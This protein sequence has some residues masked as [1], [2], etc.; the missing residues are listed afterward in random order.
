MAKSDAGVLLSFYGDDFS[1]SAATAETLT[2]TGVPT[3][4]FTQPPTA[5][6]L[7]GHF[8]Q[9]RAI[10]VAGTARTLAVD[11]LESH[12]V[13]LFSAMEGCRAPLFLYKV[14]S[15][16]DSSAWIGSIGRAME[17]GMEVLSAGLVPV[18]AGAP[19]LGRFTVFG[20][21]F[22]ALGQEAVYR[23]DRHPS[24]ANHPVT[25][26]KESDLRLHLAEQTELRSG[27]I[28]VLA[29]AKGKNEIQ[30]LLDEF[31]AESIPVIFLDCLFEEHLDTACQAI[32]ERA[33]SEG[34]VFLVGSHEVGYG[35]GH[36]WREAGLLPTS[37]IARDDRSASD[38]GPL[39]VLSGSCAT[40][41][42]EQIR[43]AAQ[44]GF[45][46]VEVRP[47]L[48][49]DPARRLSEQGRVI[50]AAVAALHAGDSVV[51][52]SAVGTDDVRIDMVK[53]T[54]HELALDHESAN[55]ILGRALGEIALNTLQ[56]SGAKRF[57]VAG[58]DTAGR[59]QVPLRTRALQV[60]RSIGVP[61]PLCY[62]Y[63]DLAS[64]NGLEVAFKGGQ[65]GTEEYFG[66]VRA[67]RTQDFET[68]ALGSF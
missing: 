37:G 52:H 22:A 23:L 60:A 55:E 41:T 59:V 38:K 15:T 28:D 9:A 20:H 58:G 1:G 32:W 62:M 8:P 36:A 2:E 48:L 39:F 54:A 24:M 63:S 26:M 65:V 21:H 68:A 29:L 16:F 64:I 30:R 7:A 50:E 51:A 45:A 6:F 27:S 11:E 43:W 66:R 33:S 4:L 44:N 35:L 18:L 13:P 56:L 53:E 67:A 3:M 61:A 42:G 46:E 49:L 57:V 10:G 47:R 5:D 31:I 14:C 19:S 12:L 34:R 25:P 40:V 17:I